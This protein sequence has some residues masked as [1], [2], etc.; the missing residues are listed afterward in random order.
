MSN[1]TPC[2]LAFVG[3]QYE[4]IEKAAK[5]I[6]KGSQLTPE[7]SHWNTK[8]KGKK[9]NKSGL[10]SSATLFNVHCSGGRSLQSQLLLPQ[11]S[12]QLWDLCQKCYL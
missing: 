1:P 10:N 4:R 12:E 11:I 5:D 7:G 6:K 8:P 9:A 2:S 3:I